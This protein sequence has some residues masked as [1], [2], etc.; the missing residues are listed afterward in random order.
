MPNTIVIP[1]FK[2]KIDLNEIISL[3]QCFRILKDHSIIFVAPEKLDISGYEKILQ[4]K[5]NIERFDDIYFE[6]ILGYNKLMLSQDFYKRFLHFEY[7]LIYQLDCY[8]FRDEL[9][10][11]CGQGY[12]YIGSPWLDYFYYK[13]SK[14][15]KLRFLVSQFIQIHYSKEKYKNK[16]ILSHKVGNGGF[17]LRKVEVFLRTL[18]KTDKTILSM[19][20]KSNDSKSLF[21]EDVFWSFEA[22]INK[23]GYKEASKFALDLN[24]DIGIKLNQDKLPFG[25]HAWNKKY[26]FWEKYIKT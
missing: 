18:Q 5:I 7:M 4:Q 16:N 17:S 10:F 8:V 1:I 6:S 12:D 25:C 23:P 21:N 15:E 24:A 2:L 26:N 13:K 19:F 9:D 11:W 22:K 20:R 14:I 3:K